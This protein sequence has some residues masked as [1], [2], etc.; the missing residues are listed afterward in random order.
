MYAKNVYSL[1]L[2]IGAVELSSSQ[3]LYV[4][5]LNVNRLYGAKSR[6]CFCFGRELKNKEC[7]IDSISCRNAV[8]IVQTPLKY[9]V[10]HFMED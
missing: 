7:D 5:G 3:E 6:N 2:C 1:G 9:I 8:N 10:H 4:L